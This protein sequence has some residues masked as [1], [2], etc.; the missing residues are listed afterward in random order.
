MT[1]FYAPRTTD[2]DPILA[3]N[4]QRFHVVSVVSL[5]VALLA[6]RAVAAGSEQ[7]PAEAEVS[8]VPRVGLTVLSGLA[9]PLCA[10]QQGCDGQLSTGPAA[11]GIALYIPDDRWGFGFATQISRS[12]WREPYVGPGNGTRY[13]VDSHLRYGFAG[14]AVRYIP[15][16]EYSV[17]PVALAAIGA[18]FQSQTGTNV[19]CNDGHIPTGH[20]AVGARAQASANVS[21]FSLVSAT[22]GFKLSN[23]SVSD[24]PGPTPFAGWGFGFHVGAAIDLLL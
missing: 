19:H 15:L 18:G 3:M 17:T 20:L 4:A 22:W 9:V 24:G 14:L 21:F 5:A 6:G 10:G 13:E 16:P 8:R 11:G 1:S 23:C 2:V 7:R 12:H